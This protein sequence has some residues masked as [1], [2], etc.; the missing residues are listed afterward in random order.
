MNAGRWSVDTAV[1]SLPEG[2][3]EVIGRRLD[4]V[5]SDA[6]EAL[7]TASVIGPSFDLRILAEVLD[8]GQDRVV[9]L[10]ELAGT[11]HLVTEVPGAVDRWQFT[12]ELVRRTLADELSLSRRARVHRRVGEVLERRSPLELGA[13]ALHFAAAAGLGD[14]EP[15]IRYATAAA[16]QAAADAAHGDAARFLKRGM[17]AAEAASGLG[18]VERVELLTRIGSE[19][20]KAGDAEAALQFLDRAAV[21]ARSMGSAELL[22]LAVLARTT[23]AV[24]LDPNGEDQRLVADAL[25][26]GLLSP[27]TRA[28]LLAASAR[29][30]AYGIEPLEQKRAVVAAAVAAARAL[31][32][33]QCLGDALVS[34]L[35]LGAGPADLT[36]RGETL[37]ELH[38]AATATGR[39]DWS[40]IA[41]AFQA[42]QHLTLGQYEAAREAEAEVERVATISRDPFAA[43]ALREL[44]SRRACIDGDFR[45][46]ERL[47]VDDAALGVQIGI[48][49][50]VMDASTASLYITVWNLEGR[51][52]HV[53]EVLGV[54]PAAGEWAQMHQLWKAALRA[55]QGRL[56]EAAAA[57]G[58]GVPIIDLGRNWGVGVAETTEA[59]V[60][61]DDPVRAASLLAQLEPY[62]HL[63]C[64]FDWVQYRGAIVH[65]MGRLLN[66]ARR[67]DD[68]ITR[69]HEARTRYEQLRSPPWLV[70]V[71]RDL[72]RALRGRAGPGDETCASTFE[73]HAAKRRACW[74]CQR[75]KAHRCPRTGSDAARP[76]DGCRVGYGRLW[77]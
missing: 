76:L 27:A 22:G 9:D 41:W 36:A 71:E 59:I 35:Y 25:D 31:G 44:A 61:L 43:L 11:S 56:E 34:S 65:H 47:A 77:A 16:D 33:A 51:F 1:T 17:D 40:A 53:E 68:A 6:S 28:R 64:V 66:T 62:T 39:P 21:L 2:I 38:V 57:L 23:Y 19:T 75:P 26:A 37:S 55:R 54:V 60:R 50:G 46:A 14:I 20:A 7:R 15:A 42:D 52:D 58:K 24:S 10:L 73:T 74:A 69:L 67:F 3:R 63:D 72:A 32:D 8:L 4:R 49:P 48:S 29:L 13:L 70:L 12:H 45:E 18:D 30:G 5:G